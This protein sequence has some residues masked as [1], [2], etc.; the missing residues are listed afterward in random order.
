MSQ[1]WSAGGG[2]YASAKLSEKLRYALQPLVRF[3]QFC[4]IEEAVG[5]NAGDKLTFNIYGKVATRGGKIAENAKMPETTFPVVQVTVT[6]DEFGNSLPYSGKLDDLSEHPIVQI[7]HKTMKDD[8]RDSL[9]AAAHVEF[10]Q[11]P[12]RIVP[13]SAGFNSATSILLTEN[14]VPAGANNSALTKSHVKA[15]ADLMQERNVPTFDG[16]DYCSV[17]RPTSFRPFKD[18]LESVHQ[19]TSEGW[20]QVMNGEVGRYEGIRF[21]TQ[22][23]V[24][25]EGWANAKSD[26]VFFFGADTV[27]EAIA[28]PEEIRGKIPDDYGRGRGIAWYAILGYALTHPLKN[29]DASQCRIFKWDSAA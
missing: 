25:T 29:S 3:R 23:A 20:K 9:D 17:G 11:T 12:L 1:L 24:A 14:G 15:I 18:E 16:E 27:T 8:A 21:F 6:M 22:T 28:V 4:D 26:S 13:G 10:D 5:Q 2:Y 19:Y 7:I